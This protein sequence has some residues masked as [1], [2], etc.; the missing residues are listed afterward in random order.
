MTNTFDEKYIF[1]T[2]ATNGIGFE[3]ALSLSRMGAHVTIAGRNDSRCR[4]AQTRILE[5]CPSAKVDYLVADL[6]DLYQIRRMAV[7][8]LDR[9]ARLDILINNAGAIFFRRRTTTDGFE[10]TFAVNHLSAFLLTDL[11][12]KTIHQFLKQSLQ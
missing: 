2:G 7:E 6:S 12:L 8:Y 5:K 9:H 1:V 10:E 4:D 11:L 3:T